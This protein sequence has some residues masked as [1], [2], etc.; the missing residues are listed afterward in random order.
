ME[1]VSLDF[2]VPSLWEIEVTVVASVFV[3][4][5]Y[6]FFT[7]RG[8]GAEYADRPVV[9][10]SGAFGDAIDEKDKV[11]S[12][13]WFSLY[14]DFDYQISNLLRMFIVF[15]FGWLVCLWIV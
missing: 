13:I 9:D 5:A 15:S 12:L 4:F 6:W 2:L 7:Y 1:T 10:N 8:G 14:F 11:N 3:I